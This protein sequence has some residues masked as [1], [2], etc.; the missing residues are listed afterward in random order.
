VREKRAY[1]LVVG[2][3]VAAA[4]AVV[5]LVLAVLGVIGSGLPIVALIVAVLCLVMFRRVTGMR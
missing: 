5:G 2:G 1:Q 3:S 4:V